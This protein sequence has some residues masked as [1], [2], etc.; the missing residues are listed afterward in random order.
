MPLSFVFHM[1]GKVVEAGEKVSFLPL[2]LHLDSVF[3]FV[4]VECDAIRFL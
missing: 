4:P 3:E 1:Q 2:L